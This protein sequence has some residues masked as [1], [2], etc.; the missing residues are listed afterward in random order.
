MMYPI[1]F[2]TSASIHGSHFVRF[3]EEMN[4]PGCFGSTI[5]RILAGSGYELQWP[6]HI[7]VQEHGQGS[8]F[9][10]GSQHYCGCSHGGDPSVLQ[11]MTR[12]IN[13]YFYRAIQ[14]RSTGYGGVFSR[15]ELNMCYR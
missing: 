12:K 15:Y 5:L 1:A 7:F 2:N 10:F 8:P 6:S 14:L 13:K 4:G 3:P 11:E 9:S